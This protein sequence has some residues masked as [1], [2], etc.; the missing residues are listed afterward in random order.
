MCDSFV[1]NLG[2][3]W[4]QNP[5]S[6]ACFWLLTPTRAIESSTSWRKRVGVE[7]T[8]LAAKDRINGFEGHENH[9][10]PFAS[11]NEYR[12]GARGFQFFEGP[13]SVSTFRGNG[14]G[15]LAS[16]FEKLGVG[17]N[18]EVRASALRAEFAA[19]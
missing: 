2:T 3:T 13:V 12:D 7:P 11:V 4:E 10:T 1:V 16:K 8:I 17:A 5:R 9:R 18:F 14:G 15:L 19:L 6:V